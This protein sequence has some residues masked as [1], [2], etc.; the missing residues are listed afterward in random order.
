MIE[1]CEWENMSREKQEGHVIEMGRGGELQ[2][3]RQKERKT[4]KEEK[5]RV[6]KAIRKRQ[7]ET[8][9]RD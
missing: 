6:E 2:K 9:E 3:F 8:K 4:E 1:R 7:K 5:E